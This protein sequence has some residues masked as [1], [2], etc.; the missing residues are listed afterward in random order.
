M[1]GHAERDGNATFDATITDASDKP[2]GRL[3]DQVAA[4]VTAVYLPR[5]E[6]FVFLPI[7]NAGHKIVFTWGAAQTTPEIALV[8]LELDA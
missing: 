8:V 4:G 1:Y 3:C 6:H 7:V 2:L 5:D